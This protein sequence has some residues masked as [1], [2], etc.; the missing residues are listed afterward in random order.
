MAIGAGVQNEAMYIYNGTRWRHGPAFGTP[1]QGA[2]SSSISGGYRS[3]SLDCVTGTFCLGWRTGIGISF[4]DGTGWS[5]PK[6]VHGYAV[7]SCPAVQQCGLAV[8]PPGGTPYV[9]LYDA[10]T[11]SAPHFFDEF[12]G[13]FAQGFSCA[14]I[15]SCTITTYEHGAATLTD[16]QWV[17]DPDVP[18]STW[19]LNCAEDRCVAGD[20]EHAYVRVGSGDWRSLGTF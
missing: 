17:D 15:S 10:G 9:R 3:G 2:D 4:Y 16:G 13:E 6:P 1:A 14:T 11:W 8:T 20:Y 12:A 7:V 18:I 5:T 19:V